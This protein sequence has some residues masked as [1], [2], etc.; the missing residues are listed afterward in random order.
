MCTT[1]AARKGVHCR[2][3]VDQRYRTTAPPTSRELSDTTPHRR[4]SREEASNKAPITLPTFA[5][6]HLDKIE[7]YKKCVAEKQV[8]D[9]LR[10]SQE[11]SRPSTAPDPYNVLNV[12]TER[13]TPQRHVKT[14]AHDRDGGRELFTNQPRSIPAPATI[15]DDWCRVS[16]ARQYQPELDELPDESFETRGATNIRQKQSRAELKEGHSDS[17]NRTCIEKRFLHGGGDDQRSR[18][19]SI[20]AMTDAVSKKTRFLEYWPFLDRQIEGFIQAHILQCCILFKNIPP[21]FP[22]LEYQE[23]IQRLYSAHPLSTT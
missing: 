9:A 5:K 7:R 21:V 1:G 12:F 15:M 6:Y 22:T 3:N 2:A 20:P 10:F 8:R 18:N 11:C 16:K 19:D 14:A 4:S 23:E 17:K 13:C